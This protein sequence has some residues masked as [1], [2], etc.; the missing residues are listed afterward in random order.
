MQWR[1]NFA[2]FLFPWFYGKVKSLSVCVSLPL[3]SSMFKQSVASVHCVHFLSCPFPPIPPS[4]LWAFSP[5][6]SQPFFMVLWK[7]QVSLC[8]YL[9]PSRSDRQTLPQCSNNQLLQFTMS[10]SSHVHF[11]PSLPRTFEPFL[12]CSRNLFS[13]FYKTKSLSHSHT[14]SL[15]KFSPILLLNKLCQATSRSLAPFFL[16]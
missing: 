8:V 12:S 5:L 11:H 15:P 9:S 1:L 10:I 13:W 4:H 3:P 14:P 2:M 16:S 7:S 6:Q